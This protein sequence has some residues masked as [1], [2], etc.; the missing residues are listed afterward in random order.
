M[1]RTSKIKSDPF[2]TS[3]SQYSA[4][5]MTLGVSL[6]EHFW[7]S[8]GLEK[9]EHL[10][11][12]ENEDIYKLAFEII[13]QYFAGDDVSSPSDKAIFYTVVHFQHDFI[14]YLFFFFPQIDEDPSLIPEAT[15]AGFS[16]DPATNMQT[17]EFNF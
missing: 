7:L 13:D 6:T 9:I 12:H 10:Q 8:A 1:A 17:K 16:F 14:R 3:G 5:S 2:H 11:Q 4:D 15:Q